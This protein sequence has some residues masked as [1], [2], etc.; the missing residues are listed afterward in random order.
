MGRVEWGLL[1]ERV[2]RDVQGKLCLI[3]VHDM[4]VAVTKPTAYN[5]VLALQ[6]RGCP[7]EQVEVGLRLVGPEGQLERSRVLLRRDL[8]SSGR[9]RLTVDLHFALPFIGRYEFQVTLDGELAYSVPLEVQG[10][11]S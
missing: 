6:V 8:G 9:T 1:C 11:P 10:Q 5:G 2:E 4:L 7:H 3:G